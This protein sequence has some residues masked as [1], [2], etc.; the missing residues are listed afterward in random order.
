[1][2]DFPD[3][4]LMAYADNEL[5]PRDRALIDARLAADAGLRARL[6]PFVATGSS[7]SAF[8]DEP[9]REPVPSRLIEAIASV[10]L[11]VAR[12]APRVR[13]AR[14]SAGWLESLGNLLFPRTPQFAAA[15]GLAGLL[16]AGGAT[17]WVLGRD[18]GVGG[19]SPAGLVALEK[20]QLV[21]TG[22]LLAALETKPMQAAAT[23]EAMSG[24][25]PLQTFHSRDGSFCREYRAGDREGK[26]F[27]GVACRQQAGGE[28]RVAAHIET[29]P[30][31]AVAPGKYES[32]GGPEALNAVVDALIEGDVLGPEDEAAAI[33]RKW[34]PAATP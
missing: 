8:F 22:E 29:P 19:P 20:G 26:T 33:A 13:E 21:A 17:V 1:M 28:W 15:F 7:L 10:A 3:E 24:V 32:A 18:G 2:T 14:E 5:S 31:A 34:A 12:T 11:P 9:L 23:G 4:M 25:V 16:I 27:S 30:V 6:E